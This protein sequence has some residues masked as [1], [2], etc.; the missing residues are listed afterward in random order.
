MLVEDGI[1]DDVLALMHTHDLGK[2]AA[3]IGEVVSPDHG[4]LVKSVNGLGASRIVDLPMG[5]LLPRIC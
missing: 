3:V 5:E 1:K 4:V 2:H